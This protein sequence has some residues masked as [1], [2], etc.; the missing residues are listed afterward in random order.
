MLLFRVEPS[1][2]FFAGAGATGQ[3]P[4]HRLALFGGHHA[5]GDHTCST[6]SSAFVRPAPS[7][8]LQAREDLRSAQREDEVVRRELKGLHANGDYIV[9]GSSAGASSSKPALRQ[10]A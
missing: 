2:A 3:Q 4:A 1:A 5:V 8:L 7:S 10:L 6:S 9:G